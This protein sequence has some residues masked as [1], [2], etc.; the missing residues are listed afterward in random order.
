[1]QWLH[2]ATILIRPPLLLGLL[3][4]QP[5][6]RINQRAVAAADEADD[7]GAQ[8]DGDQE[9]DHDD[10]GRPLRRFGEQD[11]H[12]AEKDADRVDRKDRGT[13]GQA[14]V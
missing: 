2:L 12:C 4:L 13:M 5:S 11:R 10:D 8:V 14:H 7:F 1:M 9:Y 3:D 6:V